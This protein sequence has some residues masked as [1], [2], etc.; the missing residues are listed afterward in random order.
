[1]MRIINPH[2]NTKQQA[3]PCHEKLNSVRQKAS[4]GHGQMQQHEVAVTNAMVT[5]ELLT[6]QWSWCTVDPPKKQLHFS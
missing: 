4:D 6:P 2:H 1:M 3:G 5:F